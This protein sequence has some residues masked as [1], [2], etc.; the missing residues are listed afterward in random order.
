MTISLAD[1][2]PRISYTVAQGVTQTSFT[3]PFEFFDNGDLKVYVD[4][5][6]KTITTHYTVSGG[7]GST[8]TITM[9]VTGASGGS[10]VVITRDIPLARTTDFPTSGA[11]AVATLNRELDRF[12]AMQADR[13]DDN[14]RSI[15]LKDQDATSSMELPLK[16]DRV[17]KY[18][19][20]NETSGDIEPTAQAVDTSG[21]TTTLLADSAVTT[22]KINDAAV[23]TA[24]LDSASVTT[25]KIADTGVTGA[26]LNTDAISAQTALTSGLAAT[27]ELL[28]S[29]GGTLKRMDVS[30]V[31]D[32][33]K[34]LS[35]TETNKTLTSAVLNGTISGTSIKDEDDMS[36]NSAS[37]LATQQSI[38][39]YVDATVTAE[40]L[41]VTTDSGTIAID[42][43]SE[44]LT[45]SGG[46]GI[47]TSATSNTVTIAAET[48]TT[49]NLGV[50][51][52]SSDNFDV[53]SG[54]VSIKD[55]GV[56][57]AELA[58]DAVTG[59]KIADNAISEEHL[60]PSVI[61][62]LTDATIASADH[63]M[64]L[65]A[66]D[67]ALKKVDAGELGVGA[68][69]TDVVGDT[70]PQLGGN[71]DVNGN[72]IVS[73]SNGD[74]DITPNGTG[75]VNISKV[76][77]DAGAIDGTTIGANSAAAGTFSSATVTGDLTVDTDTLFV[78]ASADAVGI[79]TTSPDNNLH[80]HTDAGDEGILIKS[81]GNTSNAI[82]SDANRSGSGS[83]INNLQG[84]WNG[85]AVADMLFLTGSDTSNKDDGVITFRTSSAN[86]IS[87]RMRI[88]SS[89]N[90]GIGTTTVTSGAGWTP[91][92]VLAETSGSPAVILKGDNSQEGSVG[93]SNGLYIDCFGSTTG[94]NNNIIFRNT[95]SNSNFSAQ[96][97]MRI[98]HD[99]SVL[100]GKTA[101]NTSVAGIEARNVGLLVA[102]R[103]GGQPLLIDR[104]TDDGDLVLFRQ[105]GT[106][107]GSISVSGTTVSYNG[108]HLS[109]WS[110]LTDGT[111]DT[112]ILKGTVMTN[113]DQMAVW[114][115][116]AVAA[117]YYVDG[118]E[119]PE[120]TP[121]TYYTE[122]DT[123]PDGVS[124]GDEK[125]A[126]VYAQV[127][128]EKTP[129]VDAFT[130]DNE[131]LNCMAVS[132]VEGDTNV[133][134]VFVNWDN[135]DDQFNDM[136]IAMTGDMVI[137]IAQ[138][139][140]VARGDLLMSAGDGTAKPQDDDIV[141]SK[142]IAKVT[143]TN[144]S[145][146]YDDGS[147]LVP[148][149]LMAC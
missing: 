127:G 143:S 9:S 112:S 55:G 129:A 123:L 110:Q 114:S 17:G 69:L 119:L 92:M 35:V 75:E 77:I 97:R 30:V 23:T 147:Y 85:T 26:K 44:T 2:T 132:S 113:L 99:G 29:D 130:E 38:K 146:T 52:F 20:F 21:I 4:G 142:T 36:S 148:C 81:T 68:A 6:L 16:A 116:D 1:N 88:N 78:D 73:V 66:T 139:T 100:V 83:V 91:R 57:T 121:A 7:D 74:I 48:A 10:T 49:S 87:E 5:T 71:L 138:G 126:A 84:R 72:A 53:S 45:I 115:H 15:K 47:D 39:A 105:D 27:D 141:R 95:S 62:G 56:V 96:E 31:T 50:A 67:G 61:S 107:E 46:E 106:A 22:A 104:L 86:N 37:H 63:L 109:R 101:A 108:G 124:V 82:I 93:A 90:V 125:T 133:A 60:D 65:D 18:L 13:A 118:D 40:D 111:K 131:Q 144:V 12:T 122:D 76:D 120:I 70:T 103:D 145:H 149:V 42:L 136:N 8:G 128:D 140:T 41:D 28:V 51:S 11:F 54:A 135:D 102:T 94:T 79:G 14:D 134:G 117:T 137:R 98:T 32:Y 89:G 80:I 58:A 25:A 34:D 19:R 3:V 43:D 33:Y 64:F 59:A 24:K